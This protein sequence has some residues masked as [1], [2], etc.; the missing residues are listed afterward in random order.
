MNQQSFSVDRGWLFKTKR[1]F[2]MRWKLEVFDDCFFERCVNLMHRI[3]GNGL[4]FD[5]L[6]D[7]VF[8][9]IGEVN[10]RKYTIKD[11]TALASIARMMGQQREKT[12]CFSDSDVFFLLEKNKRN[13]PKFLEIFE[14]IL[15]FYLQEK[16]DEVITEFSDIALLSNKPIRLI[17]DESYKFFP[18]DVEIFDKKLI[19]D[20]LVFLKDYPQAHQEFSEALGLFLKQGSYK[21]CV[22]KT[23]RGLESFLRQFLNNDKSLE[24]QDKEIFKYFSNTLDSNI[25]TMFI[26]ILDSYAKLNNNRAKHSGQNSQPFKDYEVEFLFYLVGNFLQLFIKIDSANK[27]ESHKA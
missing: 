22:D 15:N 20:V 9:L 14:Y 25:K 4:H 7:K 5:Q 17:Y 13:I 16:N 6:T 12:F 19:D 26:E 21:D 8:L 27:T 3:V 1:D 11:T 23:R 2:A 18:S 24:K 10:K